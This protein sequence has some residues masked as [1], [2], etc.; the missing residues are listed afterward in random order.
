MEELPPPPP[1][2]SQGADM[3]VSPFQDDNLQCC[4]RPTSPRLR[5]MTVGYMDN[6]TS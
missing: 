5:G 2:A 1:S 3:S 6:F 4:I